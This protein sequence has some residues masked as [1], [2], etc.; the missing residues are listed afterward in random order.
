MDRPA[1]GHRLERPRARGRHL[2]SSAA[3][4]RAATSSRSGASG[5]GGLID[6][7]RISSRSVSTSRSVGRRPGRRRR[8]RAT[9][10]PRPCVTGRSRSR[11]I[12]SPM[13]NPPN[14]SA[15]TIAQQQ[16]AVEPLLAATRLRGR[17]R[18]RRRCTAPRG[19]RPG[20]CW[21]R[22]RVV[23][24]GIGREGLRARRRV[25]CG[26]GHVRSMMPSNS[27]PRIVSRSGVGR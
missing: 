6:G 21:A 3:M 20:R 27:G 19:P 16:R 17:D 8:A 15:R 18:G 22:D 24:L 1:S 9:A 12:T 25:G 2:A 14:T 4:W 11:A 13:T 7:I 23:R 10:R 26:L 5:A